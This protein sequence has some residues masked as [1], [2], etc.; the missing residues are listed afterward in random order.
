MYRS[1][2]A[3]LT[4]YAPTLRSV[5]LVLVRSSRRGVGGLPEQTALVALLIDVHVKAL[6]RLMMTIKT[7]ARRLVVETGSLLC[8]ARMSLMQVVN[9]QYIVVHRLLSHAHII[10]SRCG[11]IKLHAAQ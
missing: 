11:K 1:M 2:Q 7:H 10:L 3:R 6:G 9:T 4:A 8:Q 5:Q